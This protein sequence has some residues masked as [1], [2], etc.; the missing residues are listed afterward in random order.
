MNSTLPLNPS[1]RSSSHSIE[2]VGRFVEQQY[3]RFGDQCAGQR[4]ALA[5]AAR[6]LADFRVGVETELAENGL[7]TGL[8]MPAMLR[9]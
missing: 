3:F 6:E 5:P 1:S 8:R 4:D 2:V 7:D 9:V